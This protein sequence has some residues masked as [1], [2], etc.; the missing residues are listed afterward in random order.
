M[1]KKRSPESIIIISGVV[2]T[3]AILIVSCFF[4]PRFDN[5]LDDI[6]LSGVAGLSFPAAEKGKTDLNSANVNELMQLYGIGKSRAQAI[7]DYRI[8]NGGFL[9]VEELTSIK[10]ISENIL[11]KNIDKITVGQYSEES[12]EIQSD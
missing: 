8:K 12:Y 1:K 5:C 4:S 10:G 6:S 3:V 2:L 11:N 7:I 9:S